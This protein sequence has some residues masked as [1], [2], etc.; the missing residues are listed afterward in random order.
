MF[1]LSNE[2]KTKVQAIDNQKQQ[3]VI[4]TFMNYDLCMQVRIL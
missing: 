1:A 2:L 3:Y 4:H